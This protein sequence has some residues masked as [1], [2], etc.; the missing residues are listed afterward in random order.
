MRWRRAHR[1]PG[2]RRVTSHVGGLRSALHQP[3]NLTVGLAAQPAVL[4][5]KLGLVVVRV[6]AGP[7]GI[8]ADAPRLQVRRPRGDERIAVGVESDGPETP[9]RNVVAAKVPSQVDAIPPI[10]QRH[11][12][13]VVGSQRHDPAVIVP[14]AERD[15]FHAVPVPAEDGEGLAGLGAPHHSRGLVAL[16]AS[17]DESSACAREGDGDEGLAAALRSGRRV[18][19]AGIAGG[20]AGPDGAR[21][22]DPGVGLWRSEEHD[23]CVA[24][25]GVD[26]DDGSGGVRDVAGAG[27]AREA[28]GSARGHADDA[29]EVHVELGVGRG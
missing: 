18:R 7:G 19:G 25:G 3:E 23:L 26:D 2:V 16:L 11:V 1:D 15:G 5:V 14:G 24:R 12:A 13:V 29:R 9:G 17:R 10:P 6:W 8:R 21:L 4:G 28:A 27:G 22:L 20:G